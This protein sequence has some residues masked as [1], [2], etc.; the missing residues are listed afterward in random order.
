MASA[1]TPL[2][3]A[4]WLALVLGVS[5]LHLWGAEEVGR[6]FQI[7]DTHAPDAAVKRIEVAFVRELQQVAPAPVQVLR[8]PRTIPA[9]RSTAVQAAQRPASAATAHDALASAP[10]ALPVAAPALPQQDPTVTAQPNV[11][12]AIGEAQS[13]VAAAP[14]VDETAHMPAFATPAKAF[15]WPPSTRLSYSLTGNYRGPVDGNARVE[16][17]RKG[18]RYQVHLDVEIGPAFAPLATRRSSSEGLLSEQGLH[19]LRYEEVT[20]APLREPRTLKMALEEER[21]VL[22]DGSTTLRPPMAQDT[23]S[24]FV[25]LTWLFSTR[26]DRLHVGSTVEI[27]LALPRR[28]DRWVYDVVAEEVLVTPAGRVL[29]YHVKPR[30]SSAR[31]GEMRVDTWIA[32]TLQYLPVRI[33]IEQDEETWADLLIDRLPQQAD[34]PDS[35]VA[36]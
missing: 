30:R 34:I 4:A 1:A 32:P 2:R 23:A 24:Q 35:A 22:A 29:T 7:A 5:L 17:L 19:P 18:D 21:I 26:P 15:E 3:R 12:S 20:K 28:V 36:R 16:W 10:S 8:R 31:A 25:Q 13:V 11:A 33:R 27:P 9:A 6:A 14:V